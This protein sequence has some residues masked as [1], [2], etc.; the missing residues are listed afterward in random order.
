MDAIH[1]QPGNSKYICPAAACFLGLGGAQRNVGRT[2]VEAFTMGGD[3]VC[4]E[5]DP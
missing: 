3:F 4:H 5:T 2:Q 1:L